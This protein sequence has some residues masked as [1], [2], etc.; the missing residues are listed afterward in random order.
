MG[1]HGAGVE[2]VGGPVLVGVEKVILAGTDVFA[3]QD[4]ILVAVAEIGDAVAAKVVPG[5]ADLFGIHQAIGNIQSPDFVPAPGEDPVVLENGETV[6]DPVVE[7]G[8][9]CAGV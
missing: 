2:A 3:V 9:G 4:A 1:P 5:T 7:E 6:I 8:P